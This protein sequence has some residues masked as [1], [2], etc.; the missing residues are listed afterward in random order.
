[1]PVKSE[2]SLFFVNSL[3]NIDLF[4]MKAVNPEALTVKKIDAIDLMLLFSDAKEC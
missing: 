4:L 2:S 1:M 3:A